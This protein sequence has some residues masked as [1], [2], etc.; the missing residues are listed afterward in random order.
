MM[1][2]LLRRGLTMMMLATLRLGLNT[3]ANTVL[4][5]LPGMQTTNMPPGPRLLRS[6]I[7]VRRLIPAK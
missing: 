7:P 5:L 2:Q 4:P 3:R 1:Q 6:V